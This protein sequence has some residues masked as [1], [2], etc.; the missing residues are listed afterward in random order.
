[1]WYSEKLTQTE[2]WS[3]QKTAGRPSERSNEG[4]RYVLRRVRR[5]LSHEES[6]TLDELR[7]IADDQERHE[8]M[9]A[10]QARAEE[11]GFMTIHPP[12]EPVTSI[13]E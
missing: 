3:P 8:A 12:R 7:R 5:L 13:R 10:E 1:M 6:K 11:D 2:R 4:R 9:L